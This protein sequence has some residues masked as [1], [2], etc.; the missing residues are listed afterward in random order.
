MMS[1]FT[2]IIYS[3]NYLK[4]MPSYLGTYLPTVHIGSHTVGG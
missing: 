2:K 4:A 1:G 3:S